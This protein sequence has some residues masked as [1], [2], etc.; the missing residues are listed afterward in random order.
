MNSETTQPP[1]VLFDRI[2]Q[3]ESYSGLL[4][5]HLIDGKATDQVAEQLNLSPQSVTARLMH[6]RDALDR[7]LEHGARKG[8]GACPVA[9]HTSADHR[10]PTG[11]DRRL[12]DDQP[13]RRRTVPSVG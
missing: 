4:S 7:I 6:I 3:G 9:P 13:D 8:N 11:K 10:E 1:Q 12:H 5:A 2:S